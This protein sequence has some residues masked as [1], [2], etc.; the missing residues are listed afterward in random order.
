[1]RRIFTLSLLLLCPIAASAR[2]LSYAPLSDQFASRGYQSRASRHFISVEGGD[3]VLY[4]SSGADEPRVI[5][6]AWYRVEH[7]ALFQERPDRPPAI[8]IIEVLPS[9]RRTILSPDG[10]ATW[11][12][13]SALD[14]YYAG[15][16]DTDAGGPWA[17][18]LSALVQIGNARHPFVVRY[19][20]PAEAYAISIEGT[21]K[22]LGPANALL[23]RNADGTKFLTLSAKTLRV[24]QPGA[25]R[26]ETIAENVAAR[27]GWI[28]SDGGVYTITGNALHHY[29]N[30]TRT[31]VVTGANLV[32]IPTHDTNGAWIALRD[33]N[34]TTLL[35]H[36]PRHGLE[37]MWTD[38]NRPAIEAL[39]AGASGQTLLL[40]AARPRVDG[41]SRGGVLIAPW[42]T[43]EPAPREYH[44]L[45][46]RMGARRGF[47]HLDVDRVADGEPFVFD[48][49]FFATEPPPAGPPPS[50][51]GAG[52]G[53]VVQE[54][55]LI[56]GS[57]RQRLVLPSASR[58]TG[59]G[60]AEWRTDVVIYNPLDAPQ[61]VRVQFESMTVTLALAPREIRVAGDV[62]KSLFGVE[63]GGGPLH[64]T[65]DDHVTVNGRTYA[66][67]AGYVA[68]AVDAQNVA[69]AR[70][71]AVFSGAFPG[72]GFRTNLLLS[73]E[74]GAE[75]TVGGRLVSLAAG[76]A[77]QLNGVAHGT[78]VQPT[79]GN[80]IAS[81]VVID[82]RT[83]DASWFANDTMST[84][85]YSKVIPFA[86]S[87]KGA[88]GTRVR[89]D[90]SMTN[91]GTVPLV[92]GLWIL[93]LAS[94]GEWHQKG[95]R[96][97]PG[98]MRIVR[99]AV[100]AHGIEGIA[101]IDV[102]SQPLDPIQ[103]G[104]PARVTSRTYSVDANG[105][106]YGTVVPPMSV[107][108]YAFSGE[109]LELLS[110]AGP[111]LQLSVGLYGSEG[112]F[113]VHLFDESGTQL[114]SIDVTIPPGGTILQN[115]ARDHDPRAV[116]ILIEP[117]APDQF[118]R[119][120]A[121]QVDT[122]TGDMAY[123]GANQGGTRP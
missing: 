51:S 38:P 77:M 8:L 102:L 37:T 43:G 113:R 52:G 45:V 2:V 32:A 15:Y 58:M 21:A 108:Q 88:N 39:Y 44:E 122:R 34:A 48:A 79:R 112:P 84:S 68:M 19:N 17:R 114:R 106:T 12:Q 41:G 104:T 57:L 42:R 40:Q 82:N 16:P 29:R 98:E 47:V 61:N 10:G 24:V 73:S 26:S 120:Y 55:G 94:D 101:L 27:A 28:A 56:R 80:A 66:G 72:D 14:N 83:N 107:F 75:V 25:T 119:A 96:V 115:I 5:H 18:G 35:R 70:F 46:G 7:A 67:G 116:R 110:L 33:A 11:R 100:G 99:D 109:A 103:S 74:A 6:R 49:S 92:V 76:S 90:V 105:G 1:M 63:S 65:P 118:V 121:M 30:D 85:P 81:A 23:G 20:Y 78:I 123:V 87:I 71:P 64:F 97:E 9:S 54:W 91:P 93:P 53:D 69:S 59:V 13:V 3:V 22:R 95:Y 4:D 36:R 60:G 86:A 50:R 31:V 111:H 117:A 62:L 89:T